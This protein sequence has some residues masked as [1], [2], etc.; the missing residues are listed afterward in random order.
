MLLP[1][2]KS[3][4]SSGAGGEEGAGGLV[5]SQGTAMYQ[6]R[7]LLQKYTQQ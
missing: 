2:Q 3:W 4:R 5:K 7:L 6:E 1:H